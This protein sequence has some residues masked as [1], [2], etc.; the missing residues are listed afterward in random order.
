MKL[1]RTYRKWDSMIGRC[2]R[3]SHPGFKYYSGRGVTVCERWQDYKA[4]LTDMGEAPPGLWLDR[5]DNS[6]GYEP[7]NCRWVTPKQSAANRRK[8]SQVPGSM[9][10]LARAAGVSYARVYQRVTRGLWPLD[11]ALSVP[12][13][14][15]GGLS[16]HNRE[17]LGLR[18]R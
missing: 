10:Q 16:R 7:G 17:L 15:R 4:F 13:Q 8:R 6:K 5:I 9:R 1:T 2:Y 11:K 18:N 12:V 14:R 3:P